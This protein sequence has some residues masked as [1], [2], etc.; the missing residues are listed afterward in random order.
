MF[1]MAG[2][3]FPI[4]WSYTEK[5]LETGIDDARDD[6]G[7]PRP[8]FPITTRL[9]QELADAE[10]PL[11]ER[12]RELEASHEKISDLLQELADSTS[13]EGNP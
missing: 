12:I 10:E 5:F 1:A 2:G 13:N 3:P 4:T 6:K 9:A 8:I 7:N 11:L